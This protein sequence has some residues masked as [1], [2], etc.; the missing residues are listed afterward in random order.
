MAIHWTPASVPGAGVVEIQQK[1]VSTKYAVAELL[2]GWEGRG[3]R[4]F[5]VEAESGTDKTE[6]AY[7]VFCARNGQDTRAHS[8]GT[9]QGTMSPGPGSGS[10]SP[11]YSCR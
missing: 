7:D 11:P 4:F 6:D 8:V 10:N 5:K 3:F 1:R 2:T 9:S